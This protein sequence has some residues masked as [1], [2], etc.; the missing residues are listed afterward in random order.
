MKIPSLSSVFAELYRRYENEGLE[1][2]GCFSPYINAPRLTG[3]Y[4]ARG[5]TFLSTSGGISNDEATIIYAVC[6]EL[7]PQKILIIGNSY[8]FSTVFLA[9]SN[10]DARLIAFDKY[11]TEGI[12]TTNK[13]LLGL[14]DKE[15]IQASTPDG[16]SEVI[17]N[18]LGG[19]VDLVLIDAVHTNEMQ[20]KEFSVL[21]RYLAEKSAVVFHDVLSCNLL[22]S[23][24]FL[25]KTY[26]KYRFSLMTKSS[27]GMAVCIKGES[28]RDL[29]DL[30]KYY[31]TDADKVL[32]F[33][34]LLLKSTD[35][36]IGLF[37]KCESKFDFLPHPQL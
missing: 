7:L 29:Q 26:D 31:S 23:L 11:R 34:T 2:Y 24:D 13:L 14:K 1:V 15:V 21:D 10:P 6:Q 30:I 8:G 27:S 28:S 33:S 36:G 17:E 22:S 37:S 32:N 16:I 12:K 18:K 5:D 25:K 19:T 3:T 35:V 9:L 4:I 20:N